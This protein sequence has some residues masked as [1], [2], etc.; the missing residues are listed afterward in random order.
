MLL[1]WIRRSDVVHERSV[2]VAYLLWLFFGLL[3][4]HR[5]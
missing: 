4:I 1:V 3:G 5:F 2:F